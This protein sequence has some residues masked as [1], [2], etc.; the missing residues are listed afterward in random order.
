MV[1]LFQTR[2]NPDATQKQRIMETSN[3]VAEVVLGHLS[4]RSVGKFFRRVIYKFLIILT[5]CPH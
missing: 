2:R 3:V 5:S 1:R 4:L